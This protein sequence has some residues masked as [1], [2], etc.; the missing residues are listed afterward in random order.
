MA[1]PSLT[2]PD[3]KVGVIVFARMGSSRLP[4]K[5]LRPLGERPLLGR[6]L[7]R[8]RQVRRAAG[9]VLATSTDPSDE[10]LISFAVREGV[11][12]F[13]GNLTDVALRAFKCASANGWVAFARVCGDRPF[14]DPAAV[15]GAIDRM[16]QD[17]NNPPDLVS[18]LLGGSVAPGLVVEVMHTRGLARVLQESTDPQD[19]EHVTRYIYSRPQQ[20]QLVCAGEVPVT[21]EGLHFAVD[22]KSDLEAA[23]YVTER[24][25]DPA[26]AS[27]LE[28]AELMKAWR[29]GHESPDPAL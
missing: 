11:N 5:A 23:R 22:T 15:D 29:N 16:V 27:V 19:R 17:P 21:S 7:D 14:F 6:V 2:A 1:R 3:M 20:F 26:T 12:V 8:A 28:I 9:I 4:G 18:N 10:P 25:S 24:L 13:R